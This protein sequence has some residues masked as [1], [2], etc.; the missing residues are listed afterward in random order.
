MLKV[1]GTNVQNGTENF[2]RFM[3]VSGVRSTRYRTH[4]PFLILESGKR[5]MKVVI[6]DKV[7]RIPDYPKNAV[8]LVQWA[9]KWRSDFF[10]F[11]VKDFVD[12]CK[13]N[14]KED[15]QFI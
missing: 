10:Q 4:N 1:S 2:E 8:V 9:G 11:T 13:K 14:P 3:E 15:Y 5:D 7:Q 6:E 12:Y